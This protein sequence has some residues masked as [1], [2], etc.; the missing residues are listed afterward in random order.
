MKTSD[1]A[2]LLLLAALWG[3]SFLFMRVAAPVLGPIWLMELRVLLAA[4]V[5]VPLLIQQNQWRDLFRYKWPLFVVGAFNSA[6]PFSLLAFMTLHTTAGFASIVNATTP[7]FGVVVGFLWLQ[8]SLTLNR[9]LGFVVGFVGVAVLMGWPGIAPTPMFYLGVGAGLLASMMYAIAAIYSRQHL[10][11]APVLTVVTGSQLAAALVM[12]P[13]LPFTAPTTPPTAVVLLAVVALALFSTAIAHLL[14]FRLINSIGPTQA[15]T[16]TY[17]VP[18]FAMLWSA[19]ALHEPITLS[20]VGGCGL[21][22]LGTAIANGLIPSL[23]LG[24][25]H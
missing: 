14:Y 11:H 1:L 25:R 8:E 16:V 24:F 15:L 17:L 7:L 19:I 6:I 5:L 18:L 10:G 22:L 13:L 4:L 9:G 23:R 20:M 3:G 12:V 21:I 2:Q